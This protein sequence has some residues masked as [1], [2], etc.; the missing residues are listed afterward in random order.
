MIDYHI[1]TAHSIDA[2]GTIEE[3]C[4]QAIK[5][6]LKEIC[7]TNHCELD[8]ERNDNLIRFNNNIQPFTHECLLKLQN[9]VLRVKDY[10]KSSGLNVKF[11][12]EIGYY[13]GIEPH[14]QKITE[15]IEFDFMLG[16]IHCLNHICIDSLE[17]H[18]IYFSKHNISE[19]LENY[20]LEI[21][22]LLNSQL[23]D[24]V[25]HL[26]VYK[27]YG[28]GFYGEE[29]QTFPEEL[30]KKIYSIMAEKKIALE[31]NTAGL[32]RINEIYPS[33]EIMKCAREQGIKIITIGSDAHKV[34]DLGKGLKQGIEYAK[35]FGFD[36]VYGFDKRKPVKIKI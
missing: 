33:P 19:L 14:L 18:E 36:A 28:F 34:E 10:Y 25:G 6:G 12:L 2:R 30:L 11:G 9:Q 35:S 5:I 13:E 31:I 15:N 7:F 32:R 24:A 29:I 23:F 26:D 20:F 27:K 16:S 22:K 3:Y 4:E 8:P 17:E 21:E 1:H